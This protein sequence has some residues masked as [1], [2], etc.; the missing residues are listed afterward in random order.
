MHIEFNPAEYYVTLKALKH[1]KES[2]RKADTT[3]R[4]ARKAGTENLDCLVD[5]INDE[6]IIL[7]RLTGLFEKLN[8]KPDEE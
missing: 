6:T 1:Y 4:V 5:G 8:Q 7:Y 3:L 2:L